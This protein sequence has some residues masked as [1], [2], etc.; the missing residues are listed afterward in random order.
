ML[1]KSRRN[2]FF[3]V[4]L[5]IRNLSYSP[6]V[7]TLPQMIVPCNFNCTNYF[8]SAGVRQ[9]RWM[10][11]HSVCLVLQFLMHCALAIQEHTRNTQT[12]YHGGEALCG[13]SGLTAGLLLPDCRLEIGLGALTRPSAPLSGCEWPAGWGKLSN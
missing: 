1:I 12:H 2:D 11:A 7:G 4:V 5:S 10:A 9:F 13:H 6:A 8:C 3:T